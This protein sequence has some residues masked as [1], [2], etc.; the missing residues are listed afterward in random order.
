MIEVSDNVFA[1]INNNGAANSGFVITRDEVV[2]VDTTFFPSKAKEIL[3]DIKTLTH[4][5][6]SYVINTHYHANHIFGNVVFKGADFVASE[7][8]K[9]LLNEVK[10]N[11]IN[12]YKAKYP[13]IIQE[14]DNV[15]I[16]L[17]SVTYKNSKT[18]KFK[19]KTIRVIKLGGHSPD[20]SIVHILPDNIVFAGDLIYSGLHPHI[21]QDSDIQKWKVALN[22]IK[23]MDPKFIIPGHGE[24]CGIE[25]VDRTLEY[26]ET[27]EEKIKEI[28]EGEDPKIMYDLEQNDIFSKRG[29]EELFIDN[30]K[31]FIRKLA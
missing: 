21:T 7:T 29:F 14:L 18:F 31:F 16:I 2:V 27:L 28:M 5:R 10:D 6:I 8:T 20:S 30:V 15:E 25:E 26:F 13:D 17:P 23:E 12:I 1:F 24:V 4:R 22:K 11:Y 9:D 19:N 3:K